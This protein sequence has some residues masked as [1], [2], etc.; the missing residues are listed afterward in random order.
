MEYALGCLYILEFF[1][2]EGRT[3]CLALNASIVQV[4]SFGGDKAI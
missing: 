4:F 1:Y 2:T 3:F